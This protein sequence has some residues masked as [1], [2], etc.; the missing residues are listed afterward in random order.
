M[1]RTDEEYL[2]KLA[3]D[4]QGNTGLLVSLYSKLW[5]RGEPLNSDLALAAQRVADKIGRILY[6]R[7]VKSGLAAL[8]E[9]R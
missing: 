2:L 5:S 3:R 4:T 7:L 1:R 6:R 9:V 8:F